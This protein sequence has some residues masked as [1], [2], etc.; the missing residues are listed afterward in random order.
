[1]AGQKMFYENRL[2]ILVFILLLSVTA[3]LGG[4][5]S[6]AGG[7]PDENGGNNGGNGENSPVFFDD[8]EYNGNADSELTRFNW[9]IRTETG[10]P[11]Y[12]GA[13]WLKDNVTFTTVSGQKV[14]QLSAAVSGS[15]VS[16]AEIY[17]DQ[18]FEAGTYAARVK[19]SDTPAEGADGNYICETFFTISG[20]DNSSN[21]SECDFEY[22][23]NGGWNSGNNLYY[24]T[25]ETVD[26]SICNQTY[27]SFNGWH[28]LTMTV[29]NGT[30]TYYVDGQERVAHGGKYYPD[31]PMVIDFNLWYLEKTSL[32]SS[33][34]QQ[35]VDW[36]YYCKGQA[37]T[38]A[39]V[40]RDVADLRNRSI[41]RLDQIH[42]G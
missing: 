41:K 39:Q 2:M 13:K 20:N 7:N 6:N 33:K 36:V 38:T 17:N 22:L 15:T 42:G 30:V 5:N 12:P 3:C 40:E 23:P 37:L 11:G 24:T 9:R 34:Y 31:G 19:F 25:Y 28:T 27:Q 35:Q 8:F 10:A 1:M 4:C 29:M 26:D 21:Y 14:L 32:N 18:D 16:H